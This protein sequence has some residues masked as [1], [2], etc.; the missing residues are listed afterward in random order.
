[1]SSYA[2]STPSNQGSSGPTASFMV[3]GRSSSP[4]IVYSEDGVTWTGSLSGD[5]AFSGGICKTV[6]WNGTIWVAGGYGANFIATSSDGITWTGSANGSFF[7][8][9]RLPAWGTATR[10]ERLNRKTTASKAE[11]D[12]ARLRLSRPRE[13]FPPRTS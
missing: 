9:A 11:K 6:A 1:M 13:S 12:F 2:G 8:S 5:A 4:R 10:Q 7:T 3:A